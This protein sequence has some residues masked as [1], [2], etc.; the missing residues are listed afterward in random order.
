MTGGF[1]SR[2]TGGFAVIGR[3]GGAVPWPSHTTTIVFPSA[4]NEITSIA[5]YAAKCASDMEK[6]NVRLRLPPAPPLLPPLLLPPAPPPWCDRPWRW[7]QRRSHGPAEDD[8]ARTAGGTE[9]CS[10]SEA[11]RG[12]CMRAQIARMSV[13]DAA[14]GAPATHAN[15]AAAG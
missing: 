12:A 1:A 14:V 3:A 9:V 8:K 15:G 7:L 4:G 11:P 13:R 5:P 2:S 10:S 6:E